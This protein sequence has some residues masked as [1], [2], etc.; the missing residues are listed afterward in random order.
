M[1][2]RPRIAVLIPSYR[3]PHI[4]KLTLPSW[5]KGYVD[6]L[7]VAAD[8][9]DDTE[10]NMYRKVLEE[11]RKSQNNVEIIY[12]LYRGRRGSV[13]ARNKLLEI[14]S[15]LDAE[16]IV[17]AD[18][19]YI[20]PKADSLA[21]MALWLRKL[22]EVGAVGGR[23]I[24]ARR[25]TADPDFFLNTPINIADPL[26]KIT[27]FIF[28][29]VE[30]G[31]RYAEYLTH[32]YMTRKDIAAKVRY[33]KLFETP[34]GYR[35]ESDVQEQIKK[36]GYKLLIDPKTYVIHLGMEEGGDRLTIPES[37]RFYWKAR[38]HIQFILKHQKHTPQRIW[39]IL[40]SLTLLT[41]Y[42]PW[43]IKHILKGFNNG[44][45]EYQT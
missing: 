16:Y 39:Y 9:P 24:M 18:D 37:Q 5:I 35:E 20:L 34:T 12:E 2:R 40:T 19:D 38:N 33:D 14:A 6:Y 32:F 42:R 26:T 3:R 7:V 36:M 8:S 10:I 1:N 30:K 23:V 21:R 41:L 4:L 44:L 31:P 15:E 17:M 29:N 13:N 27:G 45:K 25:R 11:A 43:H 28:L 22:K